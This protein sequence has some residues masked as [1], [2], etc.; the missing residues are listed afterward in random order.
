MRAVVLVGGQGTRLR[1]LTLTTPK[2]LLPIAG[3]PMI[4]RVLKALAG[5][6]ITDAVLSLGYRPDAFTQAYPG[7]SVEGVTLAYAVEREPLDTAGA[8]RFAADA[9]GIDGTFVVLNGDVL[10]AW[11]ILDLVDLHRS[12]NAAATIALTPV[13][14]P[15]RF[16]VVPTDESGRVVAF[17]EKPPAG[18]EPTNYINA[19]IYVLEPSVLYQIPKG[20]RVSIERETFPALASQSKLFAMG[21]DAYWIDA[22]TPQAYIQANLDLVA[23]EIFG[24]IP[25]LPGAELV[26]E[27]VWVQHLDGQS[28]PALIEGDVTGPALIC[29]GACIA[30]KAVVS[31]SIIGANTRVESMAEVTG[32]VLMDGARVRER[33]V[34]ES[35]VVGE[36]ACVGQGAVARGL[37]MI[38]YGAKLGDG[39][40]LDGASLQ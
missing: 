35:S 28:Q 29:A 4:E 3:V 10:T 1:P 38:G 5:A 40:V 37:T 8:I 14:D 9:G 18:T 15:S 21:S 30:K 11:R 26:A 12:S 32:S 16:G 17:I 7:G 20:R 34:V 25:P 6:G 39:A 33:A 31:S 19:G 2:Q 27:Q 23:G 22:G 13:D 36:L 24:E